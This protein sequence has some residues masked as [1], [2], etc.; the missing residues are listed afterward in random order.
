MANVNRPF[1]AR[2]VSK[3][4]GSPW[5]GAL[6]RYYVPSTDAQAIFRGDFVTSAGAHTDGT[7]ICTQCAE[8]GLIRGIMVEIEP[9]LEDLNLNYRKASTAQYV[10]VCDDPNVLVE[11]QEDGTTAVGDVGENCDLELATAGSTTTG[12]SGMQIDTS[13]HKT[14]TAQLRIVRLAPIPGNAVG[15]NAI[16]QCKINEHEFNQAVGV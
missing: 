14:A 13:D 7:P 2:I 1:G 12:L 16:W 4:D 3:I 6:N 11:I 8:G 9:M 10:L 5:T 15:A